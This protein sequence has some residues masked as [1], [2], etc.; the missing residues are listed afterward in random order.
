MIRRAMTPQ[1]Q[2]DCRWALALETSDRAGGVALARGEQIVA[3]VA[4]DADRR[5]AAN[6]LP[7][8]RALC[9]AHGA[10]PNEIGLV[11]VSIGP[12]SFTGLRIGVTVA[13]M[14]ALTSGARLAA[15]PTV[16][17]IAQNALEAVDPPRRV[18]VLLDAGR[19]AAFAAT[20]TRTGDAYRSDREPNMADPAA[21]LSHCDADCAVMGEGATRFAEVVNATGLTRLPPEWDPPRVEVVH[22]LGYRRAAAGDLTDRHRLV[23]LYIRKPAAEEVWEKQQTKR[24]DGMGQSG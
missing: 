22:R 10:R 17:V 13:R 18:A 20:C 16:E 24:S 8:I 2:F 15:V 11:S 7:A 1:E 21:F 23:P 5:H 3:S 9:E 6:L 19:D 14:L 4:L 12:G